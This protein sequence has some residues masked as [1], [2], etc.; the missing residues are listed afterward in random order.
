MA[1]AFVGIH[2]Y[3]LA[4]DYYTKFFETTRNITSE[5]IQSAARKYLKKEDLLELVV[6]KK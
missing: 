3:G 6:G 2:L 5:D 4:Y 1:D